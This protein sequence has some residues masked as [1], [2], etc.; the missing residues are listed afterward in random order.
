MTKKAVYLMDVNYFIYSGHYATSLTSRGNPIG[1][2]YTTVKNLMKL[3]RLGNKIIACIDSEFSSKKERIST[4]KAHRKHKPEIECQRQAVITFLHAMGIP[5]AKEYG[6]EADDVI[7]TLSRVYS[8]K[9]ILNFIVGVDKDL[10]ACVNKYTNML[11][12]QTGEVL[13]SDGVYSKLGVYPERV[14][15]FLAMAGDKADGF[16]GIPGI[17]RVGASK[18]CN[19]FESVRDMLEN[20]E[21]LPKNYRQKI[22]KPAALDSLRES[23]V[24][25]TLDREVP[26][27]EHHYD[28]LEHNIDKRKF[29]ELCEY[30][31]FKSLYIKD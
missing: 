30:H 23:I 9:E 13:D 8:E 26:N 19:T 20:M 6:Y 4:Y 11:N 27:L 29:N 14:E 18:L 17:G 31:G 16:N 21:L 2:T 25:A 12:L 7:A 3:A 24:L 15:E 28:P 5:I 1:G 10:Y 22:N